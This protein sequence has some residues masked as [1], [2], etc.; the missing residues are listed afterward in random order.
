MRF[1]TQRLERSTRPLKAV[2]VPER[3]I[4]AV[5]CAEYGLQEFRVSAM[6]DLSITLGLKAQHVPH[7]SD[8]DTVAKLTVRRRRRLVTKVEPLRQT[9]KACCLTGREAPITRA[10]DAGLRDGHKSR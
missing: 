8:R 7:S 2:T 5:R 4:W 9:L 3:S 10:H 6:E 1:P